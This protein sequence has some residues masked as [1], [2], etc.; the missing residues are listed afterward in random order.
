MQIEE[1]KLLG[2]RIIIE[3]SEFHTYSVTEWVKD[4][5]ANKGKDPMTDEMVMKEVTKEVK[6]DI[7][8]G[9]VLSVGSGVNQINVGDVVMY[10]IRACAQFELIKGLGILKQYDVVG[11][12][13]N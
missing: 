13:N 10:N 9:I 2:D 8:T 1:I 7:Q 5:E 12:V 4:E 3:P 11:I 6:S